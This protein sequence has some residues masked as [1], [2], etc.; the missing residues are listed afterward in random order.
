MVPQME[1]AQ[2]SVS[3]GTGGSTPA[4]VSIP[5]AYSVSELF[6]CSLIA[7]LTLKNRRPTPA[8]H[9]IFTTT[10]ANPIP[11]PTTSS[12]VGD[13]HYSFLQMASLVVT[14]VALKVPSSSH[15]ALDLLPPSHRPP[16]LA[17]LSPDQAAPSLL[18]SRSS[19]QQA[20]P[21]L[22]PQQP[23]ATIRSLP[24]HHRHPL[25][26][27]LARKPSARSS[28]STCRVFLR[29]NCGWGEKVRCVENVL[30]A[31]RIRCL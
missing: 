15:A 1:C 28:T 11:R 21:S 5:G 8:S 9:S 4:T 2:I 12:Q 19:P 27:L 18:S 30:L 24:P 14:N 6:L 13:T 29:S 31:P 17:A 23:L 25:F 3:G 7:A 26:L 10:R 16:R 22:R 20:P